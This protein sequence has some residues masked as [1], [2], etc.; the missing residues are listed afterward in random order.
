MANQQHQR[1]HVYEKFGAFHV[2]YYAT[3]SRN[4]ELKRVQKSHKFCRKEGKYTS[5][6]C[7]AVKN[8]C[9]D[10]LRDKVNAASVV[11]TGDDM[12]VVDFWKDKYLPLMKTRLKPTTLRYIQHTWNKHLE[13][14]EKHFGGHT[15]QEYTSKDARVFLKALADGRTLNRTSLKHVRAV[16]S[17]IFAEAC[18]SLILSTNPW[19]GVKIPDSARDPENT[20]HYTREQS[21][22]LVSA[23]VDP[24]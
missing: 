11:I 17:A 15:L 3:E 18:D 16:A 9:E 4:G 14:L 12:K 2:R 24:R 20:P 5:T 8:L 13:N 10:F 1:G 19:M 6:T 23:L 21:E 22:D 7:R